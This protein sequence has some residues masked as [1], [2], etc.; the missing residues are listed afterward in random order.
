VEG[1]Q[2][3]RIRQEFAGYLRGVIRHLVL[4]NAR[5]LHLIERQTAAEM[6]SSL[7]EA[8]KETTYHD[9]LAWLKF[10]LE[11]R[12]RQSIL[13]HADGALF[14]TIHRSIHHVSDAF[15]ERFVPKHCAE[16]HRWGSQALGQL[17]DAFMEIAADEESLTYVGT[18][19]PMPAGSD[20]TRASGDIDEDEYLSVLYQAQSGGW[21]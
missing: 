18:V 5:R 17:L 7:C 14:S 11:K 13:E 10:C 19:T 6:I 1:R 12:V 8:K 9:R 21:R 15:F 3:G 4:T 16:A 2:A 20:E